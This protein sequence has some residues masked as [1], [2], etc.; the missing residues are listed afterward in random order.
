MDLAEENEKSDDED[1]HSGHEDEANNLVSI[2]P[3]KYS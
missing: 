1:K 3:Y 2:E